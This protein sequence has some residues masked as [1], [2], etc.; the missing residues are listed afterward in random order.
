MGA[1]AEDLK[2]MSNFK[3]GNILGFF[4][5]LNLFLSYIHWRQFSQWQIIFCNYK[6][7]Q[8]TLCSC[9]TFLITLFY[10]QKQNKTKKTEYFNIFS[11]YQVIFHSVYPSVLIP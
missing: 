6:Y 2:R 5:F 3:S 11:I 4:V 1:Q 10:I 7:K 8:H 9:R